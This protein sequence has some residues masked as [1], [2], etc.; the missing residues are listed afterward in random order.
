MGAV[1]LNYNARFTAQVGSPE[2]QYVRWKDDVRNLFDQLDYCDHEQGMPFS[3]P[4]RLSG[5]FYVTHNFDSKDLDNLIK[6]ILDAMNPVRNKNFTGLRT[7]LWTDDSCIKHFGSWKSIPSKEPRIELTLTPLWGR[8]DPNLNWIEG[9]VSRVGDAYVIDTGLYPFSC[10]LPQGVGQL[11]TGRAWVVSSAQGVHTVVPRPEQVV[12][13]RELLKLRVSDDV[14]CRILVVPWDSVLEGLATGQARHWAC[15][16][17]AKRVD[18]MLQQVR[19]SCID[20]EQ[21]LAALASKFSQTSF[22]L[23]AQRVSQLMKSPWASVRQKLILVDLDWRNSGLDVLT[24]EAI[25]LL[26]AADGTKHHT[27]KTG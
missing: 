16:V 5:C 8:C 12:F 27:A 20:P 13:F 14:A 1:R 17:A 25:R 7:F 26:E 6:G 21:R 22:E 19:E 3:E 15:G 11:N 2:W 9:L 10:T 18:R 4:L 24:V 23:V